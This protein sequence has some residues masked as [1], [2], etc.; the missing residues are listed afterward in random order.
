MNLI[1]AK[2]LGQEMSN[3]TI[4]I[5]KNRLKK[6]WNNSTTL[7]V[8]LLLLG[9][10]FVNVVI[11]KPNHNFWFSLY[12]SFKEPVLNSC[13]FLIIILNNILLFKD[14]KSDIN[15]FN[16]WEKHS[17]KIHNDLM[18]VTCNSS[19][20]FLSYVIITT[21]VCLISCG[22]DF[23]MINYQ[24]YNI[25]ACT[26][27]VLQLFRFYCYTII[28]SAIT[29]LTLINK[30]SALKYLILAVIFLFM[31]LFSAYNEVVSEIY[32]FPLSFMS[33]LIGTEF[34]DLTTEIIFT[35]INIFMYICIFF[36]LFLKNIRR[37]EDIV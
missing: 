1:M 19:I 5:L 33:Y 7:Y 13:I 25:S 36:L 29:Y 4:V 31:L 3:S 24:Y 37:K 32:E 15:F 10:S 21:S 17:R 2:L 35:T 12:T 30:S 26:Y 6:Y 27:V 18:A 16:R 22:N 34:I 28:L 11:Y 20:I 9:M 23:Y 14:F 8:I